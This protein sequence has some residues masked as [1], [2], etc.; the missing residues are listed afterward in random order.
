[1]QL[2]TQVTY[3]CTH[4]EQAL[5]YLINLYL[6]NFGLLSWNIFGLLS[7]NVFNL[8]S[9]NNFVLFRLDI[10]LIFSAIYR[11]PHFLK[12]FFA[13]LIIDVPFIHSILTSLLLSTGQAQSLT[14]LLL[15]TSGRRWQ[16]YS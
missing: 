3:I 16:L 12:T 15:H 1:M 10:Y 13:L 6:I 7:R 11:G 8:F 5:V 9:G 2:F 14:I 4:T